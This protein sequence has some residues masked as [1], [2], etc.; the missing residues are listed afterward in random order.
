[1]PWK[2]PWTFWYSSSRLK[3]PKARASS[4]ATLWRALSSARTFSSAV[5]AGHSG[6]AVTANQPTRSPKLKA[7]WKV[8]N[9]T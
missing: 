6:F 8:V 9:G 3:W 5:E 2:S 1:M 4:G 7:R